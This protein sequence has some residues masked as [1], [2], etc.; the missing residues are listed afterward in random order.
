MT[1]VLGAGTWEALANELLVQFWDGLAHRF[2]S[3]SGCRTNVPGSSMALTPQ[4]S[5]GASTVFWGAVMACSITLSP[6][7]MPELPGMTYARG[8]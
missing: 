5:R 6:S 7:I 4:L 8:C 2:G 1:D 3:T